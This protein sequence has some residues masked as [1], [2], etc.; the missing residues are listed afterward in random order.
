MKAK[1]KEKVTNE[2]KISIHLLPILL[3]VKSGRRR[4]PGRRVSFVLVETVALTNAS[5]GT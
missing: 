3:G 1:K 5:D 2:M 4:Y